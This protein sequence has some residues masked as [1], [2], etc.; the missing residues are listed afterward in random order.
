[1]ALIDS[2]KAEEIEYNI[3]KLYL[4]E[5]PLLEGKYSFHICETGNGVLL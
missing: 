2:N 1:M 5:F 4:K 3:T